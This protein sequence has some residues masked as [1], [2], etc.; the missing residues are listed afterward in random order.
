M[1]PKKVNLSTGAIVESELSQLSIDSFLFGSTFICFVWISI[2]LQDSRG[3]WRHVDDTVPTA[4]IPTRKDGCS[5][6]S[7]KVARASNANLQKDSVNHLVN[8]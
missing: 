7:N 2:S 4:G 5:E 8:Y 6:E 3:G 1:P